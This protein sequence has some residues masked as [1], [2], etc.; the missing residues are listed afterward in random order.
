M[1]QTTIAVRVDEK[2]K[3][4]FESFCNATGMNISVAINMFLKNVIQKQELPF[5]V[6]RD[7]FYSDEHIERLEKRIADI[8]AGKNMQEH[9]LIEVE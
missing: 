7:P 2:D 1:A 5:K 9:D 4:E 3:K 8:K 6:E